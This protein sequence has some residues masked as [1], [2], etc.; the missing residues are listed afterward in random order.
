[1][2]AEDAMALKVEEWPIERLVEYAR[3]PRKN[4]SEVGRMASAIKEFGFRIPI[5]AKSDGS[6]VDGHLRLKAARKL[7]LKTVPV[8]LADDLT[9]AQIKAFRLLA[10]RSANWASWDDDLLRLEMIDLQALDYDLDLTGFSDVEWSAILA[11]K[12]AGLT[13]PDEAPEP[14]AEPVSQLGD[15]W[16]MG[17]TVKCPKCGKTTPL[18]LKKP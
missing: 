7:G 4:D 3:N 5:V 17:A 1:M 8:A 2:G 14:P 11:D 10:N 15:V 6:V 13:D 16:I 9:E 18:G 12:N